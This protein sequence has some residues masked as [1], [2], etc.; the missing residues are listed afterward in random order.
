MF[1]LYDID[2]FAFY[3]LTFIFHLGAK[4]QIEYMYIYNL[5]TTKQ[6]SKFK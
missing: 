4:L 2:M 5:H 1:V 6:T 3:L